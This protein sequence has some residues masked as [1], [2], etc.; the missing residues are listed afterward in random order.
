MEKVKLNVGSMVNQCPSCGEIFN[1][2]GAF[3]KHRTGEYGKP[4]KGGYS[5]STR[6]CQSTN[7]MTKLGMVQNKLKRWIS[8]PM[9]ERNY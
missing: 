9:G 7:E 6:R 5:A 4:I 1:S 2:L 3:D 8:A